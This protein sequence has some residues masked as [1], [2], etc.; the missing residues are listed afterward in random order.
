MELRERRCRHLNSTTT[1]VVDTDA[2]SRRSPAAAVDLIDQNFFGGEMPLV[3][4][5][6][7]LVLRRHGGAHR[8]EGARDD[9]ARH[10]RERLPVVLTRSDDDGRPTRSR[11]RLSGIQRALAPPVPRSGGAACRRWRCSRT[12]CRRSSMSKSYASNRDVIVSVFMRGGADGLSLVR[13]VRRRELLRVAPDDRDSAARTP[14]PRRKGINL[15]N[16]FMFPQAMAGLDAGVSGDGSA[17]R[18]RARADS[19]TRART[20]TRSGT[21]KSASRSTR[22]S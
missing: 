5:N 11:L 2:V 18:P 6:A 14:R 17:R 22:R 9:R 4:R 8:R 15:D 1:V 10:Q 21:W 12:G 13:A 3:T 19:T 16:F 20:S 7:L